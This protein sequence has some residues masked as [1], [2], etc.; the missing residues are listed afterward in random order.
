MAGAGVRRAAGL[1][2]PDD[3]QDGYATG[4]RDQ[5]ALAHLERVMSRTIRTNDKRQVGGAQLNVTAKQL[6]ERT[7]KGY[8]ARG[9]VGGGGCADGRGGRPVFCC[10]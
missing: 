2:R 9:S 1:D 3:V 8:L 6:D 10:C 4:G 5:D 7:L